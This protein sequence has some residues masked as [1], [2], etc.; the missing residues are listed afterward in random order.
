MRCV[1]REARKREGKSC[2][3]QV[4]LIE[5]ESI[6]HLNEVI[7]HARQVG[8]EVCRSFKIAR[9]TAL[10]AGGEFRRTKFRHQIERRTHFGNA[11]I[12]TFKLQ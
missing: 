1:E 7:E 8:Y 5:G 2:K 11:R 4:H 6:L 3:R 9:N 12:K 10:N